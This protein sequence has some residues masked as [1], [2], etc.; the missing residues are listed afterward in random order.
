MK[1]IKPKKAV[2]GINRAKM[3]MKMNLGLFTGYP[4][5]DGKW[6]SFPEGKQPE[7]IIL[8]GE[9]IRKALFTVNKLLRNFPRAMPAIVEDIKKW[10]AQHKR[11]FSVLK[12]SLYTGKPFADSLIEINPDIKTRDI[13][14]I[15]KIKKEYPALINVINA[16]SWITFLKPET[17][18]KSL[19]WIDH[20]SN[21]LTD[22]YN[23]MDEYS[24][25]VIIIKIWR[26]SHYVGDNRT[27]IV[28]S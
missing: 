13:K 14:I 16:F 21:M 9:H 6:I 2:E 20:N 10:T 3:F 27:K 19:D 26:L 1:P 12:N 18:K 8:T 22:I 15:G 25:I 24:S 11:L 28:L 5:D 17:F 23:I 4:A 7:K